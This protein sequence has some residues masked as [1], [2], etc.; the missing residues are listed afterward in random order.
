MVVVV[1]REEVLVTQRRVVVGD[2]VT[3]LGLVLPV[4]DQRDTEL[5]GHLGCQLLLAQDERL[6]GVEEVFGGQA[7]QQ[8]MGLAVGGAQVVVK[9][10]MDPGL[11]ILPAPGGVDMGRPGDGERMHAV[12]ILEQVGGVETVL[13]A[14][15][16]HQAVV[17]AVVLA[18]LVAEFPQFLFPQGPVDVTVGLVVAGVAG[19]ADTVLLNDH[20]LFDGVD[21][22]LKLIA[23]VGLLVAHDAF[24]AELHMLGQAVVGLPLVLRQIRGVFAVINIHVTRKFFHISTLQSGISEYKK[25]AVRMAM[26][27]GR[28][29][30]RSNVL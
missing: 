19:I 30:C 29:L 26:P 21:G 3:E 14:G 11:H 12:L 2:G 6:E 20:R 13:A 18:V 5:G 15:P 16:R 17:G 24:L 25:G 7:G 8:P 22:V 9:P 28:R 4:E 1:H 27:N 23:G 10:G